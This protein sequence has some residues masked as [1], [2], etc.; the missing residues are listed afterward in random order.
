[1]HKKKIYSFIF[2]NIKKG[3]YDIRRIELT[4]IHF[5]N[6]RLIRICVHYYASLT[7]LLIGFV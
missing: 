4:V 2:E 5:R 6:T 1:M 3:E 7:N